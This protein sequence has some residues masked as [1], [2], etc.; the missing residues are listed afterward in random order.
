MLSAAKSRPVGAGGAMLN[1][2]K[3]RHIGADFVGTAVKVFNTS[4]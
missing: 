4:S 1:E 3:S 2:A